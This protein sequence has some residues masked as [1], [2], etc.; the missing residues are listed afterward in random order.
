[1]PKLSSNVLIAI[2]GGLVL[3]AIIY[4]FN[5]TD[6]PMVQNDSVVRKEMFGLHNFGN[7]F[8][9][10][11][12][13][14]SRTNSA[15]NSRTNS[16]TNS[17]N[18]VQQELSPE[19]QNETGE[20][21]DDSKEFVYKKKKFVRK[22]QDDIKNKFN[23][24]DFLPHEIEGDWWDTVPLQCTKHVGGIHHINPKLRIPM[25]TMA[26][27][28][29]NASHDIRGEEPNPKL[30]FM[31]WGYSTIEPDINVRGLCAGR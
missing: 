21:S 5:K 11:S 1:M 20:E 22:T 4:Y 18:N 26:G 16:P 10:N 7:N 6:G 8:G 28:H 2:F 15:A 24:Q 30:K 23:A 19:Q 3:I 13:T 17:D 12:G 27:S 14:N 31:P 29:K 25:N 9:N